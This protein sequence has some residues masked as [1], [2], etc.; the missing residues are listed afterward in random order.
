MS[1]SKRPFLTAQWRWLAMLN[2]EV[3]ATALGPLVP[4]GTELDAWQGRTYVSLVG[5]L[6][7]K[8]RVLGVPIPFHRSFEEVNLRFYVRRRDGEGWRRGVVFIRELVPRLAVAMVARALYNEKYWSL[9]MRHRIDTEGRNAR[10][11]SYSWV[12]RRSPYRMD[13]EV[14]ADPATTVEGTEPDF[15]A[16]HHWGYVTGR[17]GATS[18]YRVEHPRWRC[19]KA[20]AARFEGDARL[21][22]GDA[23]AEALSAPPASALLADGSPI[24]VHRPVRLLP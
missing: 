24:A 19:W 11:A 14:S 12:F 10:G 13:V 15:F 2:Y 9:P 1:A 20:R 6:F 8:A 21:L 23:F 3:E 16:E 17:D 5:F 22:Y 18:E 4:R 7:L